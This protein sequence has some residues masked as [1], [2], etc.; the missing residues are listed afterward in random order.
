[1]GGKRTRETSYLES[2]KWFLDR[3]DVAAATHPAA[4]TVRIVDAWGEYVPR[5][6]SSCTSSSGSEQQINT[7]P[8]PG[9]CKGGEE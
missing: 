6:K 3:Y 4:C 2:R 5:H 9:G 7:T 8:S 1:M